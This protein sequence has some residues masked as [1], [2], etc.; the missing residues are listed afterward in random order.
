MVFRY[1]SIVG[2]GRYVCP[3]T[4]KFSSLKKISVEVVSSVD[5]VDRSSTEGLVMS[6]VKLTSKLNLTKSAIKPLKEWSKSQITISVPVL[7]ALPKI[8]VRETLGDPSCK[9][10]LKRDASI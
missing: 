7:W 6:Y 4:Q 1:P 9:S 5:G 10:I 3:T 2:F 8:A